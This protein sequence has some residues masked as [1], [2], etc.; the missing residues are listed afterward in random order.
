MIISALGPDVW[1]AIHVSLVPHGQH[2]AAV[3]RCPR[4]TTETWHSEDGGEHFYMRASN[5]T[6]ELAGSSL[7]R[8]VREHWPT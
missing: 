4:R 3:I 7:L 1:N 5:A 2:T 8:Y 6:H